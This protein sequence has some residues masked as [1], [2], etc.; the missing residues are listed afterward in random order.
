[1]SAP[2][3][4][5]VP[6]TSREPVHIPAA[7]GESIAEILYVDVPAWR[8]PKTGTIYLDAAGREK[9]EAVKA[10]Y[11]GILVPH[12]L[13]QLRETVG[14]TQQGMA[15]LL[16]LGQKSWTRWESGRERPSRSMNVLLCALFDGYIPVN[17]LQ[18]LADPARRSQFQRW[19]P[20]VRIESTQYADVEYDVMGRIHELQS[21]AA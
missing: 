11:L 15:E 12:L 14:L 21:F 1:M 2:V 8:D 6:T 18:A 5:W 17:Y 4:G 7:D 13:K 16:Q 20:S 10:R 9:I 3:A 19:A